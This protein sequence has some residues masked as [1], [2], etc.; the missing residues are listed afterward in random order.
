MQERVTVADGRVRIGDAPG[1]GANIRRAGEDV[2]R[3]AELLPAGVALTP[4]RIGLVAA[5]GLATAPVVGRVRIV[6]FSTGSELAEPGVPLAAGQIY[7]SNRAM[8]RALLGAPFTEISD[9]GRIPDDPGRIEAALR[10][11][12]AEADVIV[13][14][15]GMSAGDADHVLDALRA[16]DG[17]LAVLKIALRP[18]RPLAVGRI[19]G[20]LF[21]GLPGNPYAALVTALQVAVPAIWRTAGLPAV[22][23]P[24]RVGIADFANET[25]LGRTEI[26]PVRVVGEDGLGRSRLALLGPGASA[27]L[28]PVAMA[29]GLALLP[30]DSA[31]VWPGDLLRWQPLSPAG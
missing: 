31:Q 20:A 9:R 1:P 5:A 19:G 18:G 24:S 4:V 22:Q 3:G 27:R 28:A 10:D 6:L 23:P 26:V 13:T 8:I 21:V 25:R 16:A 7:N 17:D 12:A 2:A 14:T 29:D 30:A 15:G 11:A